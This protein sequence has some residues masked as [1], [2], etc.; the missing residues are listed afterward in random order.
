[1]ENQTKKEWAEEIFPGVYVIGHE[2]SD[3]TGEQGILIDKDGHTYL[4]F[5]DGYDYGSW[6]G[7]KYE[8]IPEGREKVMNWIGDTYDLRKWLAD[9][10]ELGICV[11]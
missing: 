2:A 9:A 8:L 1:M 11:V 10:L 6:V 3:T 7:E 4:I 5:T